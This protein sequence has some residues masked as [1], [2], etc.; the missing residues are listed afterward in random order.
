[1]TED[2]PLTKWAPIQTEA[3]ERMG[4][5]FVVSTFTRER[6][7]EAGYVDVKEYKYKLPV[8]PWSSD[9][10]MKEIGAWNLFFFLRD[11]GRILYL[12][13]GKG[14]GGECHFAVPR[15]RFHHC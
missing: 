7:K 4:K 3:S 1:L 11:S 10:R 15:D 9:K 14:N 2:N 8:G 6:M 12:S 5:S 13:V